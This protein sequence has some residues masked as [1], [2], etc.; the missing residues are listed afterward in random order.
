MTP[1][2]YPSVRCWFSQLPR[3]HISKAQ[4]EDH[5]AGAPPEQ[6]GGPDQRQVAE[7]SQGGMDPEKQQQCY[8]LTL[9]AISRW[10]CCLILWFSW[11]Y[12]TCQ[13]KCHIKMGKYTM[14]SIST[15]TWDE[16]VDFPVAIFWAAKLQGRIRWTRPGTSD[17]R[18]TKTIGYGQQDHRTSLDL[19]QNGIH[20]DFHELW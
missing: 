1:L 17:V 15:W 4:S 3:C 7:A 10:R 11:S 8:D 18:E 6:G 5:R 16:D 13:K 20:G 14:I 19:S 9:P 12:W 2:Y